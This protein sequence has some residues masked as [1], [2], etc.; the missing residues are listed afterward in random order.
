MNEQNTDGGEAVPCIS[1]LCPLCGWCASHDIAV[2]AAKKLDIHIRCGHTTDEINA[3]VDDGQLSEIN[4]K[5]RVEHN[6]S[7]Q[8]RL[9]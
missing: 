7:G 9:A 8:Q 6:V 2:V 4:G 3:A 1:L 5:F